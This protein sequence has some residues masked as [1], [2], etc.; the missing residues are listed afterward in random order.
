MICVFDSQADTYYG[1]GLGIVPDWISAKVV[2]ERNGSYYFEGEYLVGG[3]NASVLEIDNVIQADVGHRTKKQWFDIVKI[4]QKDNKTFEVYAE[5][6]SYRLKKMVLLPNATVSGN[7]DIALQGWANSIIVPGHGFRTWSN[8]MQSNQTTFRIDKVSNARSALGG[9]DDSILAKWGGEYEFD[10]FTIKLWKDMGRKQPTRITFG[11]NLISLD[12]SQ[13]SENSYTHL[14]PYVIKDN[15]VYTLPNNEFIAWNTVGT[16]II[17][18]LPVN[19]SDQFKEN[20]N[21]VKPDEEPTDSTASASNENIDTPEDTSEDTGT[22]GEEGETKEAEGGH[23]ASDDKGW[24]FVFA[25]GKYPKN[26]WVKIEGKWYRFK[27]N[28]Y[29][30]EN[31]WFKDKD[32]TRYFLDKTGAMATGWT[33]VKNRWRYFDKDG[34][35]DSSAKKEF[36]LDEG[37]LRKLAQE[38]IEKNDHYTY[39]FQTTVKY[40]DLAKAGE[41]V[42]EEV[43]LCDQLLVAIPDSNIERIALKIVATNW[44]CLLEQYD[45]LTLGTLN[46]LLPKNNNNFSQQI[47]SAIDA[48]MSTI[49]GNQA[50][51][52][53]EL[54]GLVGRTGDNMNDVYWGGVDEEP[55]APKGGFKE[56]D[57]WWASNGPYKQLKRWTGD[58]W[59]TI[60]DTEDPKKMLAK[61][62]EQAEEK[63]EEMKREIEATIASAKD[64][65][66]EKAYDS[67]KKDLLNSESKLSEI[68]KQSVSVDPKGIDELRKQMEETN[69]NVRINMELIGGDGGYRYNKNRLEGDSNRTIPLGTDYIEVGHNGKGFEVG[70]EYTISWSAE[71]TPYGHR[72]L[73]VNVQS[74]FF[75]ENGHVVLRP[76]DTRL[77]TIEH[78]ISKSNQVVPMVYFGDYNIEYSGNWFKP[79][80]V[81]KTISAGDE[82]IV[83]PHTYKNV[84]DANGENRTETIW[85]ENPQI[86]I[87]GSDS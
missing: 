22:M 35:F 30:Y 14:L 66:S 70:K 46:S 78:D 18:V 25:N 36:E 40:V 8:I 4:T 38:Y 65:A 20:P 75:V 81:R 33:A 44:N 21:I 28:G 10:N 47:S 24:W 50:Y 54:K 19:F 69:E 2:R 42:I 77:P 58:S 79:V 45:D 67:F 53:R 3:E 48:A 31:Q 39:E 57:M 68:I 49:A 12:D 17:R 84:I 32:G 61:Y 23:W 16:N 59:E 9:T 29:M 37:K 76:V 51:Q 72:D 43:E 5:H 7:G 27:K 86:I 56:G 41:G 74:A 34:A 11:K 64:E 15:K 52:F 63:K 73:T 1:T 55:A 87:D 62:E 80:P 83:I 85:S 13:S 6:I 60:V 71:C 26:R 82:V